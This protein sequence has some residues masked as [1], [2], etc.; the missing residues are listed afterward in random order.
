MYR[1][2]HC[3]KRKRRTRLNAPPSV[4]YSL[5]S[6]STGL[7]VVGLDHWNP[8]SSNPPAESQRPRNYILRQ[9]IGSPRSNPVA[10][11]ALRARNL[12]KKASKQTC[13]IEVA[14]IR[15]VTSDAGNKP[16]RIRASIGVFR[17]AFRETQGLPQIPGPTLLRIRKTSPLV[18]RVIGHAP[19]NSA[20][21]RASLAIFGG[22]IP[23]SCQL[24][25]RQ[26]GLPCLGIGIGVACIDTCWKSPLRY[27]TS[28]KGWAPSISPGPTKKPAPP[29]TSSSTMTFTAKSSTAPSPSEKPS[30]KSSS[31]S[32]DA[33][34]PPIVGRVA[35]NGGPTS[36]G[37]AEMH[38]V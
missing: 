15:V 10:A 25:F 38:V 36:R 27:S 1:A 5:V 37:S 33:F 21:A 34:A 22:N 2:F 11:S 13:P 30:T 3:E 29:N 7:M 26:S 12:G 18:D 9:A 32:P 19:E 4:F 8:G 35:S 16:Y 20:P 17:E 23:W 14:T 24:Q 28:C 6:E 31:K